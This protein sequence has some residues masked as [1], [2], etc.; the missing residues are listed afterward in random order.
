LGCAFGAKIVER[1]LFLNLF[2]WNKVFDGEEKVG[3]FLL[4]SG[5]SL[6]GL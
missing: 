3:I 2:W 5:F 4:Q 6:K 1:S